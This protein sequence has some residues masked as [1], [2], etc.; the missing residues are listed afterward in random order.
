MQSASQPCALLGALSWFQPNFIVLVQSEYKSAT[1]LTSIHKH[2][3]PIGN[4]YCY[5]V[6]FTLTFY[7]LASAPSS[8]RIDVI[9][10]LILSFLKDMPCLHSTVRIFDSIRNKFLL[11]FLI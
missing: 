2:T 10:S 3:Y 9:L 11:L 8:S 7:E 4:S 6:N 1:S 5:V